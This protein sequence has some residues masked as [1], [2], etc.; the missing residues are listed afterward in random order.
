[1]RTAL[2]LV[3]ALAG[4]AGTRMA[5]FIRVEHAPAGDVLRTCAPTRMWSEVDVRAR[6]GQPDREL[7]WVSAKDGRCLLYRSLSGKPPA[8]VICTGPAPHTTPTGRA[9]IMPVVKAVFPIEDK[10]AVDSISAV[11]ASG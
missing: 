7:P 10:A 3:L 1:M 11:G 4:C 9:E 2:L 8:F 5:N 6:C